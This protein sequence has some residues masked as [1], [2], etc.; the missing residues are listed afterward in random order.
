MRFL[1]YKKKNGKCLEYIRK[2]RKHPEGSPKHTGK[3]P[4]RML[5]TDKVRKKKSTIPHLYL[6]QIK[7]LNKIQD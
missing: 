1:F 2:K 6:N 4:K 5:R 3:E 7:K